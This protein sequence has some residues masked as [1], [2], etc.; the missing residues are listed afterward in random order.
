[1]KELTLQKLFKTLFYED[2]VRKIFERIL[3]STCRILIRPK[4][5]MKMLTAIWIKKSMTM[6][7]C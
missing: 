6:L 7:T 4:V 3:E 5:Y 2:I 1:M